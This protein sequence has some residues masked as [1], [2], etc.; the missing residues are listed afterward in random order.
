MFVQHPH[1]KKFEKWVE[2]FGYPDA[3]SAIYEEVPRILNLGLV[4]NIFS[5]IK[6]NMVAL[7]EDSPQ[8]YIILFGKKK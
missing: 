5:H 2:K 3:R 6:I 4:S 8:L 1:F 7:W